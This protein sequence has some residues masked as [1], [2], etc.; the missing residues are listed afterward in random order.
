MEKN[1]SRRRYYL[2]LSAPSRRPS[3]L[4]LPIRS[5]VSSRLGNLNLSAEHI[6]RGPGQ[7][8]DAARWRNTTKQPQ[9][10][11]TLLMLTTSDER[12]LVSPVLP[13]HVNFTILTCHSRLQGN[14][15]RFRANQ[16]DKTGAKVSCYVGCTINH[17]QGKRR[18]WSNCAA[19]LWS[20]DLLRL[21]CR[22]L[23]T[24]LITTL[25]SA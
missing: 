3:P 14:A 19:G 11:S 8:V 9:A 1:N 25:K 2:Y 21:I 23:V 5:F 22:G 17:A 24:L 20:D 16:L 6:A 10:W 12:A 15:A 4:R 18:H 7:T 13:P